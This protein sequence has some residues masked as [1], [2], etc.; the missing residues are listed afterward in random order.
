MRGLQ[1]IYNKT[2]VSKPDVALIN[3]ELD[4]R[5]VKFDFNSSTSFDGWITFSSGNRMKI[6]IPFKKHKHFNNMLERGVIKNG[7]RLSK[8]SVTFMFDIEEPVPRTNGTTIGIDI[9][10]TTTL[11]C[12]NGQVVEKDVHGHSYQSI[13]EKLA[14]KKKGSK[15][16]LQTQRHRTNYL[17]WSINQ[18][19]LDKIQQVKLEDI[20]HLRRG[21]VASKSLS[22]W[23]YAELFEKLEAK[24]TDAGV[25]ITKVSSVYTSQRCSACGWTRKKN[26]KGK[27]FKC[28]KCS[29]ECD[30]DLNG[31]LNISLKLP[32]IS[33]KQRLQ[34]LNKKGFYWAIVSEEP[35]VP[36]VQKT[37]FNFN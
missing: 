24:L 23:N 10:Q 27:Q 2:L 28:D 3:P 20:K 4:S 21:K 22:H 36:R 34:Q 31:S 16:F 1:R 37:T 35:I 15:N 26:R 14:Q 32:S 13:C 29:F 33:K 5:F 25:R 9:G 6:L 18:L 12:S 7:I 11:T 30:S 8:K 19:N 17:H